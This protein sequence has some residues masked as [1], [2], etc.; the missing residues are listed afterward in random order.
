MIVDYSVGLKSLQETQRNRAQNSCHRKVCHIWTLGALI[1]NLKLDVSFNHELA[2]QV[3]SSVITMMNMISEPYII[4]RRSWKF[5]CFQWIFFPRKENPKA[6]FLL[7]SFELVLV[8]LPHGW[9][10]WKKYAGYH[11]CTCDGLEKFS[12]SPPL[13]NSTYSD[14]C[15]G[16]QGVGVITIPGRMDF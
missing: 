3:H 13:S 10:S 5:I 7:G 14:F 11:W 12:H 1:C 9:R 15:Y 6:N 8:L 4:N 2:S 16:T